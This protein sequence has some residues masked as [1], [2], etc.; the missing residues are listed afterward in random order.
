MLDQEKQKDFFRLPGMIAPM[1]RAG[2]GT[3][4]MPIPEQPAILIPSMPP[5]LI[6]SLDKIVAVM[7]SLPLLTKPQ[8]WMPVLLLSL[9][10]LAVRGISQW[11]ITGTVITVIAELWR[12]LLL[13]L[14]PATFKLCL[15]TTL[16]PEHSTQLVRI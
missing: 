8:P 4:L 10:T 12:R 6:P 7:M 16:S 14:T 1:T 3:H 2:P 13:S 11:S 15:I 5:M 9:R